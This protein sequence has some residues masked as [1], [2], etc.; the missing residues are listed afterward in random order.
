MEKV[1]RIDLS[2]A[3][4][5]EDSLNEEYARRYLGGHGVAARMLLDEVPSWAEA[6]DPMNRFIF[7]TGPLQGTSTPAT[8]RFCV[9]TKSPLTG[10]FG[11]ANSGGF[12][13]PEMKFAGYDFI[14]FSGQSPKPVY[15]W[16][17]DGRAELRDASE[18]WGLDAREAD[19]AIR[20]DL[21]DD[22]VRVA[23][24]GQA[25][26]SLVRF[27]AVMSDEANRA[28]ARCGVG[29]V[30]GFMRLKA[31]A[32]R[33]EMK[34]PV[35]DGDKLLE[36][37]KQVV[38]TIKSSE[39]SAR[40]G[41][42]G[43]PGNYLGNILVGDSP[44][45]NWVR[46]S[47]E[48]AENLAAGEGGYDKIKRPNSTCYACPVHCRPR[49]AVTEGRYSTGG[50]V[51]GPEYETL[52]ALGSNCEIDDV[53]AVAKAND[54]CNR[55]GLDTISAGATISFAMECYEKGLLNR[56]D[57]E[58][59]DLKFGNADGMIEMLHKIARREGTGHLLAEGSRRAAEAIGG[60]AEHYAIHV[61]GLEIAMHD[62]RA[63]L[64]A[65][66]H[67]A[68]A[69]TGGRHTSGIPLPY[70]IRGKKIPELGI[71]GDYDR[72]GL[73]GK[74]E[75][76]YKVENFRAGSSAAGWCQ[77][78]MQQ[79]YTIDLYSNLC[80][81]VTGLETSLEDI[82]TVGERIFNLKRV[83]N[84]LHGARASDDTLPDRLTGESHLNGE[85]KGSLAKL[86]T[87]PEYYRI[88]GWNPEN[89]WPERTKLKELDMDDVTG[90]LYR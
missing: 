19:R 10:L 56:S 62:P 86:D 21:G 59:I 80:S 53:E 8:G 85:S 17:H 31:V 41:K 23:D 27:A 69:P 44:V 68:V 47:F 70:E 12:F 81:A 87:L 38:E 32:V 18:Y 60:E 79:G 74:A 73:E 52:A 63:G 7:A 67:Y 22:R 11:D 16:I 35:A 13:G 65:G 49:V 9:V 15:A 2:R 72:F 37:T 33:G 77:I 88:R 78:G 45:R 20:K 58:G 36:Y 61:K 3:K 43:T 89:G 46:G 54:L 82:L 90:I 83:F 1:L 76:V 29:A 39:A 64:G 14:V 42:Y 55:Y 34:V 57:T 66:I 51:D 40:I 26:E 71:T 6:F 5:V 28:A 84:I 4:I 30:M 75:L 24:I 25:G 48:G 50:E